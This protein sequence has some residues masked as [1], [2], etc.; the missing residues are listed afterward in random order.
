MRVST[1]EPDAKEHGPSQI[2]ESPIKLLTKTPKG[3]QRNVFWLVLCNRKP[4]KS[5]QPGG[6]SPTNGPQKIPLSNPQGHGLRE[7]L[8]QDAAGAE[9]AG[10][11]LSALHPRAE[12]GGEDGRGG[13]P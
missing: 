5:I 10:G 2:L 13:G 12:S 6:P 9:F 11:H 8:Q 3:S 7:V 4:P 1:R